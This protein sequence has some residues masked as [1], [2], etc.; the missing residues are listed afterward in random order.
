MA[1][2]TQKKLRAA[3]SG[4][5]SRGRTTEQDDAPTAG[6]ATTTMNSSLNGRLSLTPRGQKGESS[7]QDF[8]TIR[9]EDLEHAGFLQKRRGGFGKFA[10]DS[11]KPR[12]FTITKLGLLTY[13]ESEDMLHTS[14]STDQHM[15]P[16]GRIDLRA[17][18][19]D[20]LKDIR[21]EGAPTAY[22]MQICP[23]NEEKW[24][25]CA[26]NKKDYVHWCSIF[27]RLVREKASQTSPSTGHP[28]VNYASEEEDG[29]SSHSS[30]PRSP[31]P[32]STGGSEGRGRSSSFKEQMRDGVK[33]V[34]SRMGGSRS[35]T[36]TRNRSGTGHS[37]G[38]SQGSHHPQLQ[39]PHTPLA[40]AK[41]TATAAA[42]AVPPVRRAS[43][44]T[45]KK[46]IRVSAG[47][48][49]AL[50]DW[51][52]VE[53][54]LTLALMNLCVYLSYHTSTS[55][56]RSW[57]YLGVANVVVGW[58]LVLRQRRLSAAHAHQ[59]ADAKAAAEAAAAAASAGVDG[60]A[61]AGDGTGRARRD[62]PSEKKPPA[63]HGGKSAKGRAGE[64]EGVAPD[65]SPAA[66]STLPQSLA[67]PRQSP[68]HTWCK[69]DH[70]QFQVSAAPPLRIYLSIF[71]SLYLSPLPQR[72][73]PLLASPLFI[74]CSIFPTLPLLF[75]PPPP[76]L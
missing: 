67:L 19:F 69:A 42:P 22:V 25:L 31:S 17:V 8:A 40:K 34:I 4:S 15:K 63:S 10:V 52:A 18:N 29:A 2:G 7:K 70:R 27:E 64:G 61:G 1:I 60:V 44:G 57:V 20:F 54:A 13:Y 16:R 11:W 72:S 46:G 6:T 75:A 59:L 21:S 55:A 12:Y 9:R 26:P 53:W 74:L 71:I 48:G 50:F 76:S 28:G 73:P 47:K 68:D 62:G 56:W 35:T 58:T 51:D 30:K 65:F 39:L 5:S 33:G 24:A 14:S 49:G 36:P 41:A 38:S 3:D 66:G 43:A 32:D 45:K 37:D 23:P